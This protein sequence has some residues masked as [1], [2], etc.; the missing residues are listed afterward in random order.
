MGFVDA[1]NSTKQGIEALQPM[2]EYSLGNFY[3]AQMNIGT[4]PYSALLLLET[5]TDNTW[6]QA[7]KCAIC[8][9]LKYEGFDYRKSQTYYAAACK[10]PLCVPKICKN[11]MCLYESVYINGFS[12]TKGILSID[13][14][15]FP[16]NEESVSLPD[17]VFGMG[18]E[19]QNIK[20][21]RKMG[22]SGAT[23]LVPKAYNVIK[24]EMIKYFLAYNWHPTE[25]SDLVPYDLCYNVIPSRDKKLRTLKIRFIGADLD[26]DSKRIFEVIDNMLCMII[27]PINERGL[28]LLGA[29]QQVDYQFLFDVKASLLSFVPEKC[30]F[31]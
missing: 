8:F 14:F 12:S 21:S 17:L 31:N 5:G 13:T 29:F 16:S 26:L 10:H 24:E 9:P 6:V 2:V 4:P 19:N 25:I 1:I 23:F 22:G 18:Y 20:F 7:A 11:N 30:Q 15:T 3:I 27:M 28:S